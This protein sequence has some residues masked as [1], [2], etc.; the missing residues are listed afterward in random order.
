MIEEGVFGTQPPGRQADPNLPKPLI[1]IPRDGSHDD[2]SRYREQSDRRS[3]P[4]PQKDKTADGSDER[5]DRNAQEAGGAGRAFEDRR[6]KGGCH[7]ENPRF[8]QATRRFAIQAA[9][10]ITT[11]PIRGPAT[12]SRDARRKSILK[13]AY[14]K[15]IVAKTTPTPC[16]VSRIVWNKVL[17]LVVPSAA[18]AKVE[19]SVSG[20]RTAARAAEKLVF[21]GNS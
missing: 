2:D 18:A 11:P 9:A 6:S 8:G 20:A 13:P 12:C 21:I 15:A 7:Y 3:G 19:K 1:V 17:T 14:T 5:T 4:K 10:P 16:I